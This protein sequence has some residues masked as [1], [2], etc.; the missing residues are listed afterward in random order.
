MYVVEYVQGS[1]DVVKLSSY[2]TLLMFERERQMY[3]VAFVVVLI[4]TVT[5]FGNLLTLLSL[6]SVKS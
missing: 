3:F 6:R 1:V 4:E 2:S 5:S